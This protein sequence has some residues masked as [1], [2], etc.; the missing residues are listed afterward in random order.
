MQCN[1]SLITFGTTMYGLPVPSS[2][3]CVGQAVTLFFRKLV[4]LSASFLKQLVQLFSNLYHLA[5]CSTPCPSLP[6]STTHGHYMQTTAIWIRCSLINNQ[7]HSG[8]IR[9]FSEIHHKF[10][11]PLNAAYLDIKAEF[12][13]VYNTII[14][15]LS[16]LLYALETWTLLAIDTRSLESFQIKCKSHI[17]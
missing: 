4:I 7:C 16:V 8:S 9:I 10:D 2:I 13:Y 17:L 11:R 3:Y 12:D 15:V 14:L 1:G 5:A 6:H